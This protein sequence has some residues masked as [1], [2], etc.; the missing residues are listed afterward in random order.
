MNTYFANIDDNVE[1]K[2][3]GSKILGVLYKLGTVNKTWKMRYFILFKSE[4]L[5]KYYKK[6]NLK[7]L[8]FI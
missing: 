4:K 2:I 8:P 5:L 3:D 7:V 1:F 6:E